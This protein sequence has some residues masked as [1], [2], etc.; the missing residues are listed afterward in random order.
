MRRLFEFTLIL[1]Y[2]ST[3]LL[4]QNSEIDRLI[5][6][7]LK[8]NFPSIY[9]KY[10]STD[11]TKMPYTTDSCFKYI[12]LN[13]ADI[14]DLVIWRDSSETDKLTSQ[15]IK[16]LKTGL[17]KHKE[18]RN[19]YIESMGKAQKIS[20][21]TIDMTTDKL[22]IQFLLSLNSVFEISKTHISKER[23]WWQRRTHYEGRYLCFGCWRRGA[24]TR[25]Y[26]RIHSRKKKKKDS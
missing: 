5:N 13:I 7:E 6:S 20:R 2:L 26:Q 11:Y 9:F 25:E 1:F 10:K 8:M 23:K 16:K 14:N 19:V 4:G 18:T 21:R 24:F 12:A 3:G 15:R 22:Q 17:S